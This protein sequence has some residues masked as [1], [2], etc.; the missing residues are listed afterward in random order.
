MHTELEIFFSGIHLYFSCPQKVFENHE[1]LQEM[2]FDLKL[3]GETFEIDQ[4]DIQL[5]SSI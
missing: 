2:V 5:T 1:A 4:L 3:I